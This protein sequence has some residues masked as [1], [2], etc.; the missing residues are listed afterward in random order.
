MSYH[1]PPRN[2]N[3]ARQ[4]AETKQSRKTACRLYRR[5]RNIK[6]IV[7]ADRPPKPTKGAFK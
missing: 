3:G 4:G 1:S 6:Q 7:N 5:S 2:G